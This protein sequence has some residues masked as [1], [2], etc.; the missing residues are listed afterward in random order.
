MKKVN[1]HFRFDTILCVNCRACVVA[2]SLENGMGSN[3]RQVSAFN[4]NALPGIPVFS[5][6]LACNHCETAACLIG[7]PA[8]AY[9]RDSKTGAVIVDSKKC[10][11]CGYCTWNCP[12]GAPVFTEP[13]GYIQKCTFCNHLLSTGYEPACSSA[14]PTGA[15]SFHGNSDA[16]SPDYPEWFPDKELNPSLHLLSDMTEIPLTVIPEPPAGALPSGKKVKE[17]PSDPAN[18]WSLAIFTL[19]VAFASGIAVA[20][21]IDTSLPANSGS[22]NHF[23]ISVLL[24]AAWV[25][26][27]FHLKRKRVAWRSVLNVR[28]SALSREIVLFIMFA[29]S[30]LAV[31]LTGNTAFITISGLLAVFLMITIDAVYSYSDNRNILVFH[32]GQLFLSGFTI[33]VFFAGLTTPFLILA[34]LRVALSVYAISSSF[35][36]RVITVLTV[37]RIIM[38]LLLVPLVTGM[39]QLPSATGLIF[40]IAGESADRTLY[41]LNF[42][43]LSISGQFEKYLTKRIHEKKR[44]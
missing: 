11:G 31:L 43:P 13:A 37:F 4:E 17:S 9:S 26:S 8:K 30:S 15:L 1:S 12:Y 25:F 14:C 16:G 7:C 24:A 39:M 21:M 22:A 33:A 2:C 29:S 3:I 38:I 19:L 10:I 32:S 40:L 6:S 23:T 20:Y 28:N 41:Y 36:N 34:S 44:D 35:G 18:F 5:L 42:S 27:L